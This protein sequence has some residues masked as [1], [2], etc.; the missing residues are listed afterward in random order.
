MLCDLSGTR[1]HAILMCWLCLLVLLPW[2]CFF[3]LFLA[4]LVLLLHVTVHTVDV[5][6]RPLRTCT[7]WSL[8]STALL[9]W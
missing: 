7:I 2:W 9:R 6:C 4:G 3:P 5:G 1:F 8:Q